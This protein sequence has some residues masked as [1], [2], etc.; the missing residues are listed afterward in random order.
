MAGPRTPTSILFRIGR[1]YHA[2]TLAFEG[3]TGIGA[4]RWRL[5]YLIALQPGL[6]QKDLIRRVRVDPGSITRQLSALERDGLVARRADPLDARVMRLD[7]TSMG[8]A[9][10]RRIM[11]RRRS[12]LA[13]MVVGIPRRDIETCMRTLDRIALNLGDDI[14]PTGDRR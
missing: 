6:A 2:A 11:G 3:A 5:I 4:A 12:F 1:A 7:L 10:Y 13:R 8:K 14:F 9:E